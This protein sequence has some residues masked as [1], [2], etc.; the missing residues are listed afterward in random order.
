[1]VI[2]RHSICYAI[3]KARPHIFRIEKAQ[4]MVIISTFDYFIGG[5]IHILF[6]CAFVMC[7]EQGRR[8][9]LCFSEYDRRSP[10]STVH[11]QD[12]RSP[13]AVLYGFED[14][15]RSPSRRSSTHFPQS[16]SKRIFI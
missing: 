15:R 16:T 10:T 4:R 5:V 9:P 1:M 11:V 13:T 2:G 7:G 14:G 3:A 6:H 8:S 12:Q